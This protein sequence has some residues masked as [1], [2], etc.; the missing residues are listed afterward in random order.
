M[1]ADSN[2]G[3]PANGVTLNAATLA[4]NNGGFGTS[5]RTVVL[6]GGGTLDN[7]GNAVTFSGVISGSGGLTAAGLGTTTLGG[8]TPTPAAR[9]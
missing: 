3:D 9:R 6:N 4:I 2:L 7:Q 5:A 1:G 8:R